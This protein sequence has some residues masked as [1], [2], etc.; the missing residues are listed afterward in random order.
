MVV[1]LIF[2]RR[3]VIR[4]IRQ[5]TEAAR[6]YE[7]G[8]NK[9]AFSSLQIKS[10]VT[11]RVVEL[12]RT[13][14]LI[15][16]VTSDLAAVTACERFLDDHRLL[17]DPAC[18]VTLSAV[19]DGAEV[20]KEMKNIMCG[21]PGLYPHQEDGFIIRAMER[22]KRLPPKANPILSVHCENT[23]ICDFATEDMRDLRLETLEDWNKTH[24]NLAEGEAVI[25][26]AYFAQKMSMVW[27]NQ[28]QRIEQKP[29]E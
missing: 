22:M 23:S 21:V 4:P 13:Q 27:I 28:E 3:S 8:E 25:R 6:A 2:V 19:Y 12:S 11:S 10:H 5:L 15:P 7:G 16:Y 26:A 24:P 17:V 1:Y 9:G 20:L 14:R 18:G 29:A